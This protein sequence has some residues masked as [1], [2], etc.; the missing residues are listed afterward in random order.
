MSGVTAPPPSPDGSSRGPDRPAEGPETHAG[1]E[2]APAVWVRSVALSGILVL[3]V[4]YTMY[5]AASLIM[6]VALAFL[7]SLVLS[8]IVRAMVRW[9]IPQTLAALMVMMSVA[10][11]LVAAVYALAEPASEWMDK[12]PSELRRLEYKLAWVKEPIK[13][14]QE[15]KEQVKDIARVDEGGSSGQEAA[16]PQPSFSLV[17]IVLNRT[18]HLVYGTAV[19]FILLFFALASGD[20]LL[21]KMVQVT[22]TL[23]DKKRVVETA[24]EIQR[25]VSAYLGTITVINIGVGVVIAAAMYLLGMPN[26]LL[27]GAVV[28]V[29]NYIPYLGAAISIVIVGFVSLLTFDTVLQMLL[30]PAVIFGVNVVE[31]QFL[32]PALAGRRLSLSPVAVFLS[33]VVLGWMWG[34]IGV[35]MAVPM[36]ATIKLV[37]EHVEVLEPAATFLGRS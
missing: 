15:T 4:M 25:H 34:V 12:A 9:R 22:P 27:W 21:N 31:G 7:L 23:R 6:P 3:M 37:C 32:T 14:I 11:T 29:L 1:P 35:L 16:E 26:P 10:A 2:D 33:I 17:D 5:F 18:P 20:A 8:P 24:R 28:G 13:K 36:L 30:P 19:M